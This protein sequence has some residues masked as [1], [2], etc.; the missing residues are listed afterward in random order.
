MPPSANTA[1]G[2]RVTRWTRE[3]NHREDPRVERPFRRA[4][5]L[6]RL[7]PLAGPLARAGMACRAVP[8]GGLALDQRR[9]APVRRVVRRRRARGGPGAAPLRSAPSSGRCRASR[10]GAARA[11]WLPVAST[12]RCW[13]PTSA[14]APWSVASP[15]W[16]GRWRRPSVVPS[17]PRICWATRVPVPAVRANVSGVPA[18]RASACGSRRARRPSRSRS[19]PRTRM[20]ACVPHTTR[21]GRGRR[22][23]RGPPGRPRRRGARR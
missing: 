15:R 14:C 11:A 13:R 17:V 9:Q 23:A 12:R 7:E 8:R 16:S 18:A 10:R 21:R 3:I 2:R 6:G 4:A 20:P 5:V 1:G 19:W 22:H